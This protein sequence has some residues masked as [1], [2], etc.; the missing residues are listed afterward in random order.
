MQTA[1]QKENFERAVYLGAL[2]DLAIA[3]GGKGW[4]R[5]ELSEREYQR[6]KNRKK[7]QKQSRKANR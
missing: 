7:A 2:R 1:E 3:R 4:L 5:R 6:L